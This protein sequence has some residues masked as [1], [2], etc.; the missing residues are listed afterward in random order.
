MTEEEHAAKVRAAQAGD[1]DAFAWLMRQHRG[2]VFGICFRLTDNVHDAEDLAHDS[3]VEAYV[4]LRSLRDPSKFGAWLRTLTLNLCRM[5]YRRSR[6]DPV[7]FRAEL[8]AVSDTPPAD[9]VQYQRVM[10]GLG[11]LPDAQRLAL[12][13]HCIEGLSYQETATFLDI[14]VGT[15]MSRLHRARQGLRR[16]IKSLQDA[17]EIPMV[18]ETEFMRE[19]DAEVALLLE[20][21]ED[22][23]TAMERLS[24]ILARSPERVLELVRRPQDMATLDNLGALLPRLGVPALGLLLGEV[25]GLDRE[26]GP[27]A[28]RVLQQFMARTRSECRQIDGAHLRGLPGF[29][30]YVLVDRLIACPHEPR[31]TAGLLA[32]LMAVAEDLPT[33]QLL[34]ETCLC[35][36][37]H[38]YDVL[39]ERFWQIQDVAEVPRRCGRVPERPLGALCI[40]RRG[41]PRLAG[42]AYLRRPGDDR[43]R[44]GGVRR[45]GHNSAQAHRAPTDAAPGRHLRVHRPRTGGLA[46]RALHH[47]TLASLKVPPVRG[48]PCHCRARVAGRGGPHSSAVRLPTV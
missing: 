44:F 11:G 36:G 38:A 46:R 1:H 20:M 41:D 14:P 34:C 43:T 45:L 29:G 23:R 7:E 48:Q 18:D 39:L 4:R 33:V 31:Q 27:N 17:E 28:L 16:Q 32:D 13:L 22:D 25:L 47:G 37:D 12:V 15:V 42:A 40:G 6:R 35:L 26:G 21:F 5:W 9:D 8:P 2:R 24:A 10:H 30:A 3:F 19:V